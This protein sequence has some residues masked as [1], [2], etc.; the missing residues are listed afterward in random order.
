MAY[1]RQK[2]IPHSPAGW[3][4]TVTGAEIW[5]LL[6]GPLRVA[7]GRILSVSPRSGGVVGALGVSFIGRNLF[8][9]GSAHEASTRRHP[10]GDGLPTRERGEGPDVKSCCAS[11]VHVSFCVRNK[12]HAGL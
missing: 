11:L 8:H 9:E 2:R 7:D 1:K 12:S 6:K 3:K 5:C 10:G 4:S